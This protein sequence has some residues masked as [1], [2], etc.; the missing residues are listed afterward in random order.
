MKKLILLFLFLSP[1]RAFCDQQ[2][3]NSLWGIAADRAGINVA[4]LYS[5]A[6][7][8]SGMRWEDGTYRPWPWTLN[9]NDGKNIVKKGPR[10]YQ[11]REEMIIALNQFTT[12]GVRNIDIGL[13]QVNL[14]WHGDKVRNAIDL[15]D[16]ATNIAVAAEYI[17]GMKQKD[18]SRKVSDYHSPTNRERGMRYVNKVKRFEDYFSE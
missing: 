17:K 4:T 14:I 5:M 18:V 13:M 10:R 2:L 12:N 9:I 3:K 15:V 7:Q 8:E 6:V 16:P 1:T 11:T